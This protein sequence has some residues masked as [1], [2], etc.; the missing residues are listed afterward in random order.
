MVI[1]ADESAFAAAWDLVG[2]CWDGPRAGHSLI[3]ADRWP[4]T[5]GLGRPI[6]GAGAGG[7]IACHPEAS[8]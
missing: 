3:R 5:Q 7:G 2:L 1:S 6:C 8:Y 4:G